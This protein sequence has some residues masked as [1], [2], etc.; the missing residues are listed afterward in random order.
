MQTPPSI[1]INNEDEEEIILQSNDVE[2]EED[3]KIRRH[4]NFDISSVETDGQFIKNINDGSL[5]LKQTIGKGTYCKVKYV[6]CR[7]YRN[8]KNKIT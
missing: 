4:S 1:P 6:E 3:R 5:T 2:N 8:I 7:V